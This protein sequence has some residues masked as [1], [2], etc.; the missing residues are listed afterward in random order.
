LSRLLAGQPQVLVIANRTPSRAMELAVMF[1]D[2]GPVSGCGFD[3]LQGQSFDLIINA[4]AASLSD[5]VPSLPDGVLNEDGWCYDMMYGD[6][7][8]A[9]VRWGQ[10]H[11]AACALD[12]LGMLVEQAAESFY[13]WRRVRPQTAPV[14]AA[15]RGQASGLL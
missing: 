14:I 11:G 2:L 6:E 15:L 3:E 8:T 4:T 10:E 7:P 5:A 9:F 12:G 13:L 1:N